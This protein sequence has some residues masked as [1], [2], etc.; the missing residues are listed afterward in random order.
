[1][2]L[3]AFY[4]SPLSTNGQVNASMGPLEILSGG[5]IKIAIGALKGV[6]V[7][8]G[9]VAAK[10]LGQDIL[11]GGATKVFS[12]EKQALVAMAKGDAK[13]GITRGD[14]QAYKELNQELKDPFPMNKIRGPEQH[15]CGAPTS[16]APHAHIGPVDHIPV[17]DGE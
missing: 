9:I 10:D 8:V 15:L 3:A 2:A 14:L 5:E 7:T 16:M 17:I 12:S 1:M 11:K 4:S 13:I 6:A